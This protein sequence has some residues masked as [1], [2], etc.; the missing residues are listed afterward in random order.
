M[1]GLAPRNF[2]KGS[3]KTVHVMAI[4]TPKNITTTTTLPA[5]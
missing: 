1:V 3:R 4:T 5:V 2:N